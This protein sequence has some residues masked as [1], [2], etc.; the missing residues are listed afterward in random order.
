MRI[1][2]G[3]FAQGG[4]KG[5]QVVT[6]ISDAYKS[7]GSRPE[8]LAERVVSSVTP[9][10]PSEEE[11]HA[12]CINEQEKPRW[13]EIESYASAQLH[14]CIGPV[15]CVSNE[16]YVQKGGIWVPTDRDIYRP[17]ALGVLPREWRTQAHSLEVIKRLEGEQQVTH[18]DFCGAAKF[19]ADRNVLI[20]VQNGTLRITPDSAELLPTNPADGFT[21][22]LP[23]PWDP[24]AEAPLFFRVLMETLPDPSDPELLLDVLAT[25]LIPDCRFEAALVCQGEAGTG[26]STIIAPI[27]KIF[28][29]ACSSLSLADLCHPSGYKLAMLNHKLINLAT[30]LNT[31][32]MEDT[33]LFK[34]LVSGESFTARPIYGKPFEM[35]STATLV[36]LANSLPRFKHGTDAEVRRLRFVRF[37]RKVTQPDITLKDRVSLEAPGVFAELVRRAQD[38][39]GGHPLSESGQ[40]GKETTSRFAVS[41]DPVGQFVQRCCKL[42]ASFECEKG[43]L[44]EAFTDFREQYGISDRFDESAFFKTLYDRFHSVTQQKRRMGGERR[45]VLVGID[46]ADPET[47]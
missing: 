23:V 46:L 38:L 35:C 12:Q 1:G 42:G 17:M 30:E 5:M 45:R 34:Q 8:A 41:N 47:P 22:A 33:G 27:T 28:G 43:I 25:A 4:R 6:D 16:W 7:N 29:S 44:Y 24:E 19:D 13:A 18:D 10:I 3:Y 21:S 32:E 11:R 31:L 14:K 26:K 2:L 9:F 40:F 15:R 36:F 39:L 37:S 20:A